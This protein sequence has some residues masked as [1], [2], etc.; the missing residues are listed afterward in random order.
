MKGGLNEIDLRKPISVEKKV[1]ASSN[2][3]VA[4]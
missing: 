1:A 2:D 3:E 4:S